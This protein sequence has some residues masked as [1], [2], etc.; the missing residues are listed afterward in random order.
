[1]AESAPSQPVS[2]ESE[3]IAQAWAKLRLGHEA[4][5]LADAAE[6]LRIDRERVKAHQREF[7]GPAWSEPR[8]DGV[9]HIGDV[10][11]PAPQPMAAAPS[12]LGTLGKVALAFAVSGPIGAGLAAI[13]LLSAWLSKPA[14][15]AP[16]APPAKLN[17]QLEY[18]LRL[19][20][21]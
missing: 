11:Q 1:M 2:A 9:I 13:P 17:P 16:V 5:M 21:P 14:A 3:K 10:H 6:G 12:T 15:V 8:E 4:V 20:S 7:L 18:D 19:G